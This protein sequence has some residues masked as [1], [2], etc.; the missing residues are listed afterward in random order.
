M[1]TNPPT[2]TA[3]HRVPPDTSTPEGLLEMLLRAVTAPGADKFQRR[4]DL[5]QIAQLVQENPQIGYGVTPTDTD[6]HPDD[7]LTCEG[8]DDATVIRDGHPYTPNNNH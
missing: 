4:M 6:Q 2:W 5:E 3:T 8:S 7:C 1:S